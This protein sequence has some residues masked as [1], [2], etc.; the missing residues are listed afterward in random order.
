[1]NFWHVIIF[2][3]ILFSIFT[4]D[5]FFHFPFRHPKMTEKDKFFAFV[6]AAHIKHT[7]KKHKLTAVLHRIP[8][9][10]SISD[11]FVQT[12]K[13][14][15]FSSSIHKKKLPHVF[16]SSSYRHHF[17]PGPLPF[18]DRG[19]EKSDPFFF[20]RTHILTLFA[21]EVLRR[22]NSMSTR[23]LVVPGYILLFL[24]FFFHVHK[25]F[26][27]LRR[28]ESLSV[29]AYLMKAWFQTNFRFIPYILTE[30]LWWVNI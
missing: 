2:I 14:S 24:F 3:F 13:K 1:M 12:V 25:N 21:F 11:K 28:A 7:I 6:R 23:M 29:E 26:Q 8:S 27:K 18:A 20:Y 19:E 15:D 4:S 5:I 22:G 30:G 9:E 17:V 16:F 10:K